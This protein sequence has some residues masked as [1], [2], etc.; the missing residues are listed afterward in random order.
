ME[1]SNKKGMTARRP[2]QEEIASTKTWGEWSK[3]PSEFEWDY[4][5]KETCYILEGKA[6]V[7]DESGHSIAFEAGDWVVFEKGI[8]CSW[9]VDKTIRNRYK[10][11][12]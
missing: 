2:S 7:T 9:K 8:R 6:E 10:F 12:D 11:G 4:N 5:E 3:S 1:T